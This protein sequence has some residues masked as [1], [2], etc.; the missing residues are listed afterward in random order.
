MILVLGTGNKNKVFEIAPHL[1]GIGIDLKIAGQYGPFDPVEDGGTLEA[2][3][4]IKAKA[5]SNLVLE[6][7]GHLQFSIADDTGLFIDA[8][9]GRPGVY[10]AR[11]AGENCH[12]I[13]NVKKVLTEMADVPEEKRTAKFV[14]VIALVMAD[15]KMDMFRG[16]L[17]GTIL[18]EPRGS[19]GFGYDPI[20]HVPSL[21]KTLAEIEPEHKNRISHRGL[22]MSAFRKKLLE[23]FGDEKK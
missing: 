6:K 15:Q 23:I 1:E 2:N 17:S 13:E 21:G 12:F 18:K 7:T 5:A 16:E 9:D 8:L 14:C 20:F 10:S 3:A 4:L 11:Y 22:A 19:S